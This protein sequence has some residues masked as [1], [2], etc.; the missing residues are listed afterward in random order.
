[1]KKVLLVLVSLILVFSFIGCATILVKAPE[2]KNLQI[3]SGNAPSDYGKSKMVWY[4][5]WGL[6]PIGDNTTA[7]LLADAP[8]GSKVFVKTQLTPIDAIITALLSFATIQTRTVSVA[9]LK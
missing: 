3:A 6:V 8:N 2:G 9:I 1:M 5:L 7:D 4:V